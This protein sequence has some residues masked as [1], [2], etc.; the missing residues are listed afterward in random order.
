MASI[1]YWQAN[2]DKGIGKENEE[3]HASSVGRMPCRA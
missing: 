3:V 1:E 2:K